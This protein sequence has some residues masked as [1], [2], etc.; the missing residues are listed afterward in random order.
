LSTNIFYNNVDP[1]VGLG[2]VS[3]IE[4]DDEMFQPHDRWSTKSTLTVRG[5]LTGNCSNDITTLFSRQ[6]QLINAFSE[7]HKNFEIRE[8]GQV[9]Y[10]GPYTIVR[11]VNFPSNQY[12]RNLPFEITLETYQTNLFSGVFGVETP[13]HTIEYSQNEDN[14]IQVTRTIGA[15]GFT[16]TSANA[17]SNALQNAK[18]WVQARTGFSNIEPMGTPHFI[19]IALGCVPCLQEFSENINRMEGSYEVTET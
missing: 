12:V 8:Q 3:S 15:K 10:L 14:T 2:V 19:T 4:K 9:I 11:S 6:R 18:T 13:S 1:L 7:D 5:L 17:S 16:T